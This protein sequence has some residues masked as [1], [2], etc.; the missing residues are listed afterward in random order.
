MKKP[1]LK[2]AILRGSVMVAGLI[3]T[4]TQVV[5]AEP[6][7]QKDDIFTGTERFSAGAKDSTEVNLDKSM[8]ALAGAGKGGAKGDMMSKMDFVFVHSYEYEK[9][10]SYDMK[11]VEAFRKRL[12]GNGWSHLVKE[13]SSKESTDVCVKTDHEGQMTELVV[14]DAEPL[15]LNFVHLKGHMSMS[16]M[17]K[18]GQ[19]YGVQ[20][21]GTAAGSGSSAGSNTAPKLQKR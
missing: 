21:Q 14:I 1:L 15:E 8:L 7:Q 5:T 17:M 9:P 3:L 10:G 18:A 2:T 16:D 4:G 12:E 20:G 11:D 6:R 19:K 13:R